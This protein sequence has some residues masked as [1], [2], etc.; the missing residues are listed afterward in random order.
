VKNKTNE[1]NQRKFTDLICSKQTKSKMKI[2]STNKRKSKKEKNL[3]SVVLYVE[4]EKGL[5]EET[6][7]KIEGLNMNR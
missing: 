5:K 1:N 2:A 3:Q 6:E 4:I 7:E